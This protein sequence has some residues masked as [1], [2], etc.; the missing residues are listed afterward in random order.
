MY[1]SLQLHITGKC[2]LSCKHCYMEPCAVEMPYTE[3]KVVINQY[4]ELLKNLKCIYKKP[5]EAQIRI[6]GGEPL[7][8][9]NIDKI[10]KYLKKTHIP[11]VLMTNGS[12][13]TNTLIKKLKRA[14]LSACQVSLDGIQKT[15]D[16][17]RGSGNF[18]QVLNALDL[19]ASNKI[20]SRVSF[21]ANAENY[22]EFSQIA[23]ICRQHKVTTLWSDRYVPIAKRDIKAMTSEQTHTY[24]NLLQQ[25][26]QNPQNAVSGL[27]I[28]NERAL[29]FLASNKLPYSCKAGENIIVVNECGE[30][31]PCRRLPIVCGNIQETTLSNVYFNHP[32]FLELQSHKI[33]NDCQKCTHAA[34]CRGGA[35]C[36]SYAVHGRYDM[37][38]PGCFII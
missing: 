7:L 1:I 24:I 25:E 9:S 36:I 18:I 37:P 12:L 21:T 11:F 8:H 20:P 26:K 15:H 16:S 4:C 31:L 23:D 38:D 6:T 28:K 34:F 33:P 5:I 14:G 19:L 27:Q 3:F 13:I 17:I 32:L 30:I 2:N 22:T 29:Q 10:F 35:R